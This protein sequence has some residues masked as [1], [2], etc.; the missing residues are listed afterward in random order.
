M[1]AQAEDDKS[2]NMCSCKPDSDNP[3]GLDTECFNRLIMIECDPNICPTGDR[4][5]NRRF[6]K[7]EYAKVTPFK[8]ETRGWGLK[9]LQDIKKGQFV[10]EYVG[11][12]IDEAECESRIKKMIENNETNFYFLTIDRDTII[13]AGPKG[14]WARF[15][16]HSCMPNCETQKWVVNGCTRVG[17]FAIYD[18]QAGK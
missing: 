11:E 12:L 3:C 4:C 1:Q 14:N 18:I 17:L 13:D 9:A 7:R 10:I 2:H 6:R 15:M 16:N 5:N 8:T